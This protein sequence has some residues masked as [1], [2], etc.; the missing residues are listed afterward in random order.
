MLPFPGAEKDYSNQTS[1]CAIIPKNC[2][3][4]TKHTGNYITHESGLRTMV[5]SIHIEANLCHIPW[6][7]ITLQLM[8]FPDP[9]P[10]YSPSSKN[11]IKFLILQMFPL[12]ER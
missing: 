11:T 2:I 3:V 7:H 1:F 4:R 5:L 6:C 10:P 8:F 9:F 12:R